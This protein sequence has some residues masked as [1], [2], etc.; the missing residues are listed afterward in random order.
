MDAMSFIE[1]DVALCKSVQD[2]EGEGKAYINQGELF[3]DLRE[4]EKA[5]A[6][7]GR[8][9]RCFRQLEEDVGLHEQTEQVLEVSKRRSIAATKI[10]TLVHSLT[11]VNETETRRSILKDLVNLCEE[12]GVDGK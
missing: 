6:A 9:L 8:A 5:S 11:T 12:V 10:N 4:F 7:Y 1:K 2:I 3:T